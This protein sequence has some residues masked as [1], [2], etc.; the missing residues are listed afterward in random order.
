MIDLAPILERFLEAHSLIRLFRIAQALFLGL[1]LLALLLSLLS[2][3]GD[4]AAPGRSHAGRRALVALF[5]LLLAGVYLYQATWQLGGFARPAFVEFMR[6]FNQRPDNPVARIAR[7]RLLDRNG[8]TLAGNDPDH[9][10]RRLYPFSNAVCHVT[11]YL[12]PVFGLSGL[13][14]AD[15]AFLYGATLDTWDQRSRFT[16]NLLDRRRRVTG[17][18]RTLTLD[19]RLQQ[20]AVRLLGERAG[21]VVAL[22]PRDGALLVLASTPGF[23]PNRPA[24]ELFDRPDPGSPLL[25]RALHG[26]YPPGSTFKPVIAAAAIEAGFTGELDCPAIG[27]TAGRG[28]PAIRDHEALQA[29]RAGTVWAGHGRIPMKT[30]LRLSSN[31]YFARL[32]VMLGPARLGQMADRL[33]LTGPITV[34]EG[35]SGAVASSPCR[36]PPPREQDDNELAQMS[37]GQGR[38]LVTPLQMAVLTAAIANH[39]LAMRPRLDAGAPPRPLRY[40][41]RREAAAVLAGFLRDAVEAGTGHGADVEGLEVAGKTG[42]AQNPA[43]DDHAWFVCFAPARQPRLALAVIVENGGA[44][45]Q[46]AVPIAADL[47]RK[48]REI[49]WLD[50]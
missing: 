7:G 32:G 48:A 9:G 33:A 38:L 8:E 35:S 44:G 20:E 27:Y 3:R 37:I 39:G 26:L 2:A 5:A 16:D 24:P 11:G 29:G 4:R 13:E 17:N 25:N 30:A 28:A 10:A 49:G 42:T 46:A 19:I 45:S 47:L 6:R 21:A 31:V 22:D 18:D 34:F 23:N 1:A 41:F 36:V 40:Y 14:Q 15:S 12:S 43:G 50:E